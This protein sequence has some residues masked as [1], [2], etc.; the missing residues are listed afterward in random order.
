MAWGAISYN[1]K[2]PLVILRGTGR[3][4]VTA[5]DYCE[6]VLEPVIGPAFSGL[7]SYDASTSGQFVEDQA[8]IHGTRKA[9]VEVK[10]R[11]GIPLHLR[12]S[13]SPDLNPIENVW[14]TIKSSIKA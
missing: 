10:E 2:S 11:L 5:K 6:Q 4:G 1:W 9:L 7:L 14:R 13:C 12:L 3:K 8:P